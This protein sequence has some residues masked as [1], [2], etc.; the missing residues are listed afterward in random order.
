MTSFG[1]GLELAITVLAVF[2]SENLIEL[3]ATEAN[4]LE[5]ASQRWILGHTQHWTR[6][7]SRLELVQTL[8]NERKRKKQRYASFKSIRENDQYCVRLA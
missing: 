6:K 5:Q 1:Y 8:H 2:L 3:L 7:S 4:S